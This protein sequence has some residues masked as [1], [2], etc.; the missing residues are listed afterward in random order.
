MR[1]PG[2]HA[3]LTNIGIGTEAIPERLRLRSVPV[4]FCGVHSSDR[5][6]KET[7][8]WRTTLAAG[9]G[10]ALEWMKRSR[11]TDLAT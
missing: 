5:L 1:A 9:Q 10:S 11:K 7:G 2:I 6:L 8:K 3:T 4:G